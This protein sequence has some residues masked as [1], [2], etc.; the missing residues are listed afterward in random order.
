VDDVFAVRARYGAIDYAQTMQLRKATDKMIA[1]LRK[2]IRDVDPGDYTQAKAFI[3]ALV[4]E[5][6][7]PAA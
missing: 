5:A 1:V 6:T 4:F 2:M 7:K 3:A